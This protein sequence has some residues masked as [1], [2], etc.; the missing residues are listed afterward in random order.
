MR[1]KET[2]KTVTKNWKFLDIIF[3]GKNSTKPK[4]KNNYKIMKAWKRK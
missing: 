1:N 4:G 2:E 3:S